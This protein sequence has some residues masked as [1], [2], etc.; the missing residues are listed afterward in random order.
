MRATA[1]NAVAPVVLPAQ[2]ETASA[3]A[4]GRLR[5]MRKYIKNN[6]RRFCAR[7]DARLSMR[8]FGKYA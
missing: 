5:G 3:A 2:C 8:I 6:R 1:C 4:A 7:V